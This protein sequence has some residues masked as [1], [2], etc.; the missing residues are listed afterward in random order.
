MVDAD[1]GGRC[2][3]GVGVRFAV[4]PANRVENLDALVGYGRTNA[5]EVTAAFAFVDSAVVVRVRARNA[6]DA[7]AY[8]RFTLGAWGRTGT[9]AISDVAHPLTVRATVGAFVAGK[10]AGR[11]RR[12]VAASVDV[13]TLAAGCITGGRAV[14]GVARPLPVGAASD[15]LNASRVVA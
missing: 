5:L 14:T 15:T 12:R 1:A 4:T 9:G 13:L 2:E 10:G 7:T 3:T 8:L 11:L 6:G